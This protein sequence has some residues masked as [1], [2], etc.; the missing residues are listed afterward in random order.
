MP[1]KDITCVTC[2]QKAAKSAIECDR[3]GNWEHKTCAHV[4]DDM[5]GLINKVPEN[6]KF[7]CTPVISTIFEMNA[8]LDGALSLV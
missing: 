7:F 2:K 6:I 8:S 3:C 4:N 5:Y 1:N